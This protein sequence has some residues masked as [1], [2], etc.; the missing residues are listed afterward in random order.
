[1]GNS[2]R[3]CESRLSCR[4][5]SPLRTMAVSLVCFKN[6]F[7]TLLCKKIYA[8]AGDFFKAGRVFKACSDL[9]NEVNDSTNVKGRA[10]IIK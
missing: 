2:I 9:D 5:P 10:S 1:M 8:S 3:Q 7:R 4:N 6:Y